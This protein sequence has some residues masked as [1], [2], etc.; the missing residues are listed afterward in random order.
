MKTGEGKSIVIAMLAI[1][2]CKMFK[3]SNGQPMKVH[4]LENNKGLLD[5]DYDTYAPFYAAFDLKPAKRID[6]TAD[7]CY[8][9]KRE[10]NQYFTQQLIEG[11]LDLSE[12][13]LIVDE[14]DDLVVNESP[15]VMMLKPDDEETHKYRRVYELMNN[16]VTTK[17]DDVPQAL[18]KDCERI[19]QEANTK[20]EHK[21][22]VKGQGSSSYLMLEQLPDGTSR[23]PRLALTDDWLEYLNFKTFNTLPVKRTFYASLCTPHMYANYKCIFG[24]TGSVGGPAERE[25]IKNTYRAVPYEVPQ[26]LTTCKATTKE[27]PKNLGVFL[28]ASTSNQESKVVEYVAANYKKVP[29]LV[30]TRNPQ[31]INRLYAQ[32]KRRLVDNGSMLPQH[33]QRLRERDDDGDLQ[34]QEWES[35]IT[36][37]TKRHGADEQSYC[38][39]TVTDYFGGRGHDYRVMDEQANKRERGGMLVIAT[40]IP[41]TR[42][43]IQWAGRTARQDRPGQFV[44]ILSKQDPPFVGDQSYISKFEAI[45]DADERIKDLTTL[46]DKHIKTTLQK[47]S[48]DQAKGAWLNELS[49]KYYEEYPRDQS[50]PW[51]S[52]SHGKQDQKMSGMLMRV[53]RD[54][55]H[56]RATAKSTFPVLQ[57]LEGPPAGWG[58]K[59][60]AKFSGGW[61]PSNKA[62]V[63]VLDVSHSMNYLPSGVGGRPITV[64][65]PA[66]MGPGDTFTAVANDGV[67]YTLRVPEHHSR[68]SGP[69][70]LNY[71]IASGELKLKTCKDSIKVI[72]QKNVASDDRVG[73]VSFADDVRT[74]ITIGEKASIG[75]SQV[76]STLSSL[77][78]RG[79]TAFYSAVLEGLNLLVRDTDPDSMDRQKWC[80][81]LTDGT[82]N[83]SKGS[84]IDEALTLLAR[85]PNLNLALITIGDDYDKSAFER[86]KSASK[87]APGDQRLHMKASDTDSISKAFKDIA[88]QMVSTAGA[89]E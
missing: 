12:V 42:E 40:S 32:I 70:T 75:E 86:Y 54:G 41:D 84:D 57:E 73:L 10:N 50:E 9:L 29:V 63:F 26:F 64:E 88:R 67:S 6:P 33:L 13:I 55:A 72:I 11:K 23:L 5:R 53:Y 3:T 21:D 18:W 87:A 61:L 20:V 47:F 65:C 43:W 80:V 83:K 46:K 52:S 79:A 19:V 15:T 28:E 4:V 56:I 7:I 31:E 49:Q 35:I 62:L 89:V 45:S 71:T 30:I 37:A 66:G 27:A 34:D 36:N 77:E 59:E 82:D 74:D 69:C 85:T 60:N 39:V 17:P 8:C 2:V 44:V 1:F 38:Y 81:A 76:L 24:L 14:V 22:Y 78:T 16:G 58:V 68:V 48:S 51:P 25:Y